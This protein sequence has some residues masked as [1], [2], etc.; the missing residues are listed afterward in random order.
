LKGW[1]GSQANFAA[2]QKEFL[3]RAKLNSLATTGRYTAALES[4]AA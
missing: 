4:Q 2:G 1:G 3:K